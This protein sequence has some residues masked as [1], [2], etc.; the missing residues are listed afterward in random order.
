MLGL[1]QFFIC[2]AILN[3][4]CFPFWV[5]K[6]KSSLHSVHAIRFALVTAFRAI[7]SHSIQ[8]SILISSGPLPI[9]ESRPLLSDSLAY[10]FTPPPRL[11]LSPSFPCRATTDT[12]TRFEERLT[13]LPPIALTISHQF[14]NLFLI[15]A[16]DTRILQFPQ[17]QLFLLTKVF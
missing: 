13:Q 6:S 1:T 14:G 15:F 9:S 12:H 17:L 5:C 3:I 8:L 11:T 16:T 7:V 2:L 10:F 4:F